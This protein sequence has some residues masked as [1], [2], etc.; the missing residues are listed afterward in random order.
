[1]L[2]VG[3]GDGVQVGVGVAVG[4]EVAV[5]VGVAVD[6]PNM[7]GWAVIGA[8]PMASTTTKPTTRARAAMLA[9]RPVILPS[10]ICRY[11]SLSRTMVYIA[12]QPHN[13]HHL[14]EYLSR[15]N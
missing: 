1:L 8:P 12:G 15:I 4:V 6:V 14:V 2:G 3:V 7:G 13:V 10:D 5:A 9:T 11:P